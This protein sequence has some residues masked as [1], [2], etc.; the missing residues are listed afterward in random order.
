MSGG[1][2][3]RRGGSV[4]SRALAWPLM[5]GVWCYRGTIGPFLAGQ[6]RYT[7]TCSQYCL[8]AL[9]EHGAF[10]GTWLTVRRLAR[11]HP[12][13]RGGYDPVPPGRGPGDL[14]GLGAGGG[15]EKPGMS[16]RKSRDR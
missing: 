2:S 10:R 4:V 11:C 16:E 1:V 12:F 8:E 9:R 14:S 7:P 6:C 3:E 13:V 5:V 15:E